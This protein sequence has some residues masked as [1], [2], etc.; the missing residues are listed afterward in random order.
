[1]KKATGIKDSGKA[2]AW[3][4]DLV[5]NVIMLSKDEEKLKEGSERAVNRAGLADCRICRVLRGYNS[6]GRSAAAATV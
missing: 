6:P 2:A 3:G 1:M 4:P 5:E